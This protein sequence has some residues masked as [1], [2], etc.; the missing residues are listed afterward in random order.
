M[1]QD[2]F[3]KA[4]VLLKA[5]ITGGGGRLDGRITERRYSVYAGVLSRA[6][7]K[8]PSATRSVT[9]RRLRR[10]LMVKRR[11]CMSSTATRWWLT[12]NISGCLP[13]TRRNCTANAGLKKPVLIRPRALFRGF[14]QPTGS[15]LSVKARVNIAAPSPIYGL[16]TRH[17][18]SFC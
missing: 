13:L 10:F 12:A 15:G 18:Q 16:A 8:Q 9:G 3:L 7:L 17:Y 5:D 1:L 4:R 6:V 11:P 14:W 2:G